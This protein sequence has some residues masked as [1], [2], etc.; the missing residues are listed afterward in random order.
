MAELPLIDAIRD[1]VIMYSEDERRKDPRTSDRQIARNLDIPAPQYYRIIS[2]MGSTIRTSTL[3]KMLPLIS[4]YL[5]EDEREFCERQGDGDYTI[6]VGLHKRGD[7]DAEK[8]A[9][10]LNYEAMPHDR[11]MIISMM[12]RCGFNINQND[13]SIGLRDN[14]KTVDD[15]ISKKDK[16]HTKE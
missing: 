9:H 11:E 14:L 8:A 10:W 7:T 4:K 3:T 15:V 13:E 12:E 6:S 1:A 5:S 16:K 2:G